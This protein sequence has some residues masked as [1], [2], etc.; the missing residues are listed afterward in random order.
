MKRLVLILLLLFVSPAAKAMCP[1]SVSL[2]DFLAANPTLAQAI[3]WDFYHNAIQDAVNQ[4]PVDG[5][6]YSRN[7][8][9]A[10]NSPQAP[11]G[12]AQKPISPGVNFSTLQKI[13]VFPYGYVTRVYDQ[14]TPEAKE[15]LRK[16]F[17]NYYNWICKAETLYQ[18]YEATSF[19]T[20]PAGFDAFFTTSPDPDPVPFT[21]TPS[22]IS[23]DEEHAPYHSQISSNDAWNLYARKVAFQLAIEAAQALPWSLKA[24][25]ADKLA[26]LLGGSTYFQRKGNV[27]E[28][29]QVLLPNAPL[30]VYSFFAQNQLFG[31]TQQEQANKVFDWFRGYLY[32]AGNFKGFNFESSEMSQAYFHYKGSPPAS[33]ILNPTQCTSEGKVCSDLKNYSLGCTSTSALAAYLMNVMNIPSESKYIENVGH[34]TMCFWLGSQKYCLSHGDDLT[35]LK[36]APEIPMSE[37]PIPNSVYEDWFIINADKKY[38]LGRRVTDLHEKYLTK[39]MLSVY[40]KDGQSTPH[41]DGKL[42]KWMEPS[43]LEELES[44][45]LWERMDEKLVQLG[46][47]VNIPNF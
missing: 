20:K 23:M 29:K 9:R 6:N 43:T 31:K 16:H 27:F 37:V 10:S 33:R 36:S 4:K 24:Y 3:S 34:T 42:L 2:P 8:S 17:E 45:H 13:N 21:D 47:C 15:F 46:G 44:R 28:M 1:G 7:I 12:P 39:Q 35:M 5:S 38:N 40:C 14:W 41:G 11:V 22:N 18:N 25:P 26:G 32:H 30:V 19:K